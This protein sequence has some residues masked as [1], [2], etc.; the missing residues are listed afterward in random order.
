MM[1]PNAV[2][3]YRFR[4]EDDPRIDPQLKAQ[5]K[6]RDSRVPKIAS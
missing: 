6:I 4:Y 2:I 5:R 1:C 3:E